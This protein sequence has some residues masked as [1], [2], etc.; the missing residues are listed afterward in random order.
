MA[1]IQTRKHSNKKCRKEV[2]KLVINSLEKKISSEIFKGLLYRL[3]EKQYVK[4]SVIGKITFLSLP[5]ESQLNKE[6]NEIFGT[7]TKK[8]K[9]TTAIL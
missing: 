3:I 6:S 1:S 7:G 9:N 5:K 8:I 2:F 4:L